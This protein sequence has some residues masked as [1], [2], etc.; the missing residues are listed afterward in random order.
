MAAVL[1]VES[2]VHDDD[3]KVLV[4]LV[5][6]GFDRL[7]YGQL[8]VE[9]GDDHGEPLLLHPGAASVEGVGYGEGPQA[10]Y[11]HEGHDQEAE[12]QDE[13][14]VHRGLNLGGPWSRCPRP[15]NPRSQKST[16]FSFA[17]SEAVYELVRTV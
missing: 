2:V 7:S 1:S 5:E 16:T 3:L 4:V 11:P 9:G 10:E 15:V 6:E 13:G 12:E 17:I 14:D 8:L